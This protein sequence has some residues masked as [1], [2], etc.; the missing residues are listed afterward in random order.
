M[1]PRLA[2]GAQKLKAQQVVLDGEIVA[3]DAQGRPS[4]Q[5]LQHR[6]SNPTHQIVFYVFDVLHVNGRDVS[7]EPL[8]K[9]R[10]RL[11]AIVGENTTVRLSQELPG[12]AE[13]VVAAVRAAGLEG[14]IAKRKDSVYQPGE[15]SSDWVKLKLEHQQVRGTCNC[16]LITLRVSSKSFCRCA[17]DCAASLRISK[18]RSKKNL[19]HSRR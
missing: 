5:T 19:R 1:Y 10:G 7:A 2:A 16:R 18:T 9:R 3:L 15:G 11:P 8:R 17:S 6:S 4:F 13:T 14:V 12:R